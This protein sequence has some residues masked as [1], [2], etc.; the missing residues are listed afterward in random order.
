MRFNDF[1]S[2]SKLP[3]NLGVGASFNQRGSRGPHAIDELHMV[4]SQQVLP[5]DAERRVFSPS[6]GHSR[7]EPRVGR[8]A[9]RS[10]TI[11]ETGGSVPFHIL[12]QLSVRPNLDMLV[13][14]APLRLGSR[15][16]VQAQ[17]ARVHV[18]SLKVVTRAERPA[19]RKFPVGGDFNAVRFAGHQVFVRDR[20]Y[21][22]RRSRCRLE[23]GRQRFG[24]LLI[25][26]LV[27]IRREI[28]RQ[29]LVERRSISKLVSCQSFIL[30][31]WV[32]KKTYQ[33]GSAAGSWKPS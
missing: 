18:N 15:F 16:R 10:K 31:V 22:V 13:R 17:C 12:P 21:E 8:H 4:I 3:C 32:S 24:G 25:V 30:E 14:V 7:V 6:P 11:H 19:F 9:L 2:K 1:C 26:V 23:E 28:E 33:R 5:H 20:Q 27:V 29:A